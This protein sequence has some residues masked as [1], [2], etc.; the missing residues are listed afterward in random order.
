VAP[1]WIGVRLG[2]ARAGEPRL[3]QALSRG[4]SLAEDDDE[5]LD[6]VPDVAKPD[7]ADL[8]VRVLSSERGVTRTGYPTGAWRAMA[9]PA[10]FVGSS[11][12]GLDFA[13]AV[14]SLLAGDAEVTLW[15]E[16]FFPVGNTFIE[17]L[18]S[19]LPRF[20]FAA[21]VLTPDDLITSR[22]LTA[23]SPRDNA[24][25][26]L[27][28]FMG[29]LGRERTFVVRPNRDGVKIPSDLAGLTTAAYDWPR[30]DGS[31][32]GA[33]G[34]ACDSIREVIRRLGFSE[35][36]VNAQVRAVQD[37][38]ERQRADI[39]GILRF[40][41][42]SFATEY[43]LTHLKKLESRDPFSFKRS[44]AFER[45]LRRLL[46]LG[47]IARRPGRGVRSMLEAG[48]DVHNHLEITERGRAYLAY[49]R[50]M[51]ENRPG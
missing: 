20:D 44:D 33:V 11:S 7:L 35:A 17:S 18:V 1:S 40:L 10:L 49:C 8:L 16:G 13:R 50:Q 36:R 26:E 25:F 5:A 14:R 39:D 34:P 23:L 42:Q 46:T 27:G 45:E 9:R 22:D 21:V 43:E 30:D 47:L 3:L 29:R 2:A 19:G 51:E 32:K 24:L 12:E 37:E 31:H 48:D 6:W 4:E 38:Q 28:L 41:L 15:N